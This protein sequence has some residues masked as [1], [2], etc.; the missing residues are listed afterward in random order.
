MGEGADSDRLDTPENVKG[1]LWP[2]REGIIVDPLRKSQR[3]RPEINPSIRSSCAERRSVTRYFPSSS[4]FSCLSSVSLAFLHSFPA[5]LFSYKGHN[6][7]AVL[8]LLPILFI[9]RD[10]SQI[11]LSSI[12]PF[13]SLKGHAASISQ[14]N[15]SSLPLHSRSNLFSFLLHFFYLFINKRLPQFTPRAP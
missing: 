2:R 5:F 15:F 4:L 10:R 6:S 11:V 3:T 7:T 13:C 8:G 1:L 14:P 12:S 9:V